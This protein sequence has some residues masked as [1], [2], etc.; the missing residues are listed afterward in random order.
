VLDAGTVEDVGA[1]VEFLIHQC[2]EGGV[3]DLTVANKD[4]RLGLTSTLGEVAQCKSHKVL[5]ILRSQGI[6]PLAQCT[7]GFLKPPKP[8]DQVSNKLDQ[9][10]YGVKV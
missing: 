7:D 5:E 9:E 3:R 8:V 2:I 1:V 4:F 10:H 6:L